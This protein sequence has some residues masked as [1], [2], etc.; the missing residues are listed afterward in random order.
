MIALH[1][2]FKRVV[3]CLLFTC[4]SLLM[5]AQ[6][7]TRMEFFPATDFHFAGLSVY[8][9]ST[10][11][12]EQF[13]VENNL[14]VKNNF[15]PQPT[16]SI[17]GGDYRMSFIPGTDILSNG[18]FAYSRNTG[19]FEI[20]YLDDKDGTWKK[21]P[22]LPGGKISLSSGDSILEFHPGSGEEVAYLTA[23]SVDGARFGIFYID[24]TRWVQSEL[25]PK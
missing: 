9:T 20:L 6:S 22:F 18:L 25:Y 19:E 4:A 17:K 10:G 8:S 5:T 21:N 24:G 3:A 7:D 14:W 23:Y 16:L 2:R 13:Y 15:I 12:F 11:K 1:F